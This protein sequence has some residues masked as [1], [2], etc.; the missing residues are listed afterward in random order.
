MKNNA[1][2]KF[3]KFISDIDTEGVK[4]TAEY[5]LDD[6]DDFTT[7]IHQMAKDKNVS[8]IIIGAKGRSSTTALFLGSIAEKLMQVIE[9]YPLTVVRPKGKTAGIMEALMEI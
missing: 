8:G 6:N 3:E 9:D 7:D 1:R 5:S 4:I 2:K